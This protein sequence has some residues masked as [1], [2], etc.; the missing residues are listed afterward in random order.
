MTLGH[1]NVISYLRPDNDPDDDNAEHT[2]VRTMSSTLRD[3]L[4][5]LFPPA[6]NDRNRGTDYEL[7]QISSQCALMNSNLFD[8]WAGYWSSEIYSVR[9]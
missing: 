9:L 5:C 8:I 4:K 1:R 7:F 3:N 2:K 6:F